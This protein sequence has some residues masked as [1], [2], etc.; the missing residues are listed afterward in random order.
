M[1]R[2]ANPNKKLIPI[3]AGGIILVAIITVIILN[4]LE[5]KN[6]SADSKKNK[7][8]KVDVAKYNELVSEY[9]TANTEFETAFKN[10]AK[11]TDL[12]FLA[13]KDYDYSN[14]IS[15]CRNELGAST[16]VN[17]LDQ[18]SEDGQATAIKEMET[19]NPKLKSAKSNISKCK[20]IID[21]EI[22]KLAEEK[23]NKANEEDGAELQTAMEEALIATN[24][25]ITNSDYTRKTLREKLMET[26][27][28]P[29][30][31][32][33][34]NKCN[35]DWTEQA[36]KISA[37]YISESTSKVKESELRKYLEGENFQE[38]EIEEAVKYNINEIEATKSESNK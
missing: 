3:V 18:K 13:S 21:N 1:E 38:E 4:S 34:V 9:K 36:R 25:L 32:Y 2:K 8:E 28:E 24:V 5:S 23:V 27:S 35:M 29:V 26:Y 37:D 11:N 31:N 17:I 33:A 15:Q 12:G 16:N 7:D 20:T 30:A 14:I 22:T 19:L 6:D 10:Y